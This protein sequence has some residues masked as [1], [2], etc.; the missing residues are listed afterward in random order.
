MAIIHI[1][2]VLLQQKFKIMYDQIREDTLFIIIYSVV[3][4]MAMIASCYL[5]FRRANAITPDVTSSVRLRRWTG[6]FFASI[7][8]NHV[9]YM[10]I[11]FLSSSVE[12]KMTD[13]VGG[14]LD[15]MTFFPLAIIVL[16]TMLQ[17]RRRPLW[18]VAVMMAPIVA[19]G[20]FGVVACSYALLPE[21]YV[22]FLLMCIILILYMVREVRRYGRWLRDNYADLEHKEVWQS[23]VVLA[24]IL[25]VFAI[26]VFTS[27]GPVYQYTMQVI[28]VVFICYLLWRVETLS[29]LS[30]PVDDAREETA[31]T[32]NVEDNDLSLSVRNNIGPLL[33]KCCE[34]RQLYLQY[35]IS[36]TQLAQQIGINRSYLSKHFTLQGITYN[37]Y[38]NG[39]R[40]EHFINLYHEA[41]A[42]NQP[43]TVKQLAYQS[44]FRSYSTFNA[45]FKQSMGMTATAW[46][47]NV[48]E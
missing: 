36:V 1:Y 27:K 10:P 31:T 43:V 48:A 46:M 28:Y 12:I 29:D 44:G 41:A 17:D 8:F 7:A 24:V 2:F 19:G 45:A 47:N 9:W 42:T 14:L 22:Y 11:F 33:K 5:L 18:P 20:V 26:Y 6:L 39:L 21:V 13:L 3:T 32:E 25:L 15:C 16:L 40:I 38:I 23:F 34:E 35:D 4:A 30:I 37:T